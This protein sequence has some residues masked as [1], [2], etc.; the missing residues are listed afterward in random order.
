VPLQMFGGDWT[1]EKLRRV[2]KY[3]KAYNVALK[4][5]R[6]TREYI[7][8]FAGTGYR[9]VKQPDS[10]DGL[11]LPE[12]VEEDCQDFLDGSASIALK[13]EPPFHKF[14]FIERSPTKYEELCK[15]KERHPDREIDTLQGDANEHIRALCRG[16]WDY[17]RAVLFLDPFGMQ[18]TWET[19]RAIAETRAI[20]MWLLFPLGVAVSRLLKKDGNIEESLRRSLDV[21][22]GEPS[23]FG[24]F[25]RT[26]T[27]TDLF[28][29]ERRSVYKVDFQSM[30]R[31][32]IDRLRSIFPGVAEN[33]LQ[34][35][36]SKNVPLYLLCFAAGNA[37]GAPIAVDI[38]Q[39]VLR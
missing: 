2:Q 26:E 17:R 10:Q 1:E 27:V 14:T 8:A 23:W 19:L 35:R 16:S 25:Y 39:N 24:A 30:E 18:V 13:V 21:L 11:L 4:K 6:F 9:E 3:L 37:R 34:L 38:A 33:P 15:L 32:F 36:N 12:L 31:Y 7:D 5:Q 22:F 29:Q 28:G 20:D